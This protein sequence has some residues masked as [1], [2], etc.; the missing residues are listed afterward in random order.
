VAP[1]GGRIVV[2]VTDAGRNIAG[3]L[4][5]VRVGSR[6][7]R[8]RT[9]AGGRASITLG[10]APRGTYLVRATERGFSEG[11]DRFRVG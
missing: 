5:I 6:T 1:R 10:T 7:L 8:A 9:G 3:A 11:L 2:H 4:V